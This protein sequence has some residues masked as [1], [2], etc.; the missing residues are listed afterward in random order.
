MTLNLHATA[1]A[2]DGHAVLLTGPSGSGKSDLA[3]RLIDRG[4]ALIADDR[5]ELVMTGEQ[6]FASCPAS[7]R[8]RIEVRGLGIVTLPAHPASPV[9]LW[10]APGT[11]VRMPEPGF[12]KVLDKLLPC[13]I[14]APFEQSA[15]IKVELALKRARTG[16]E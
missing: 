7:I 9:A 14:V 10:V 8:G 4:A 3:L 16:L 2:I 13:L 6:L 12:H 1:I 5:V 11:P 15:P